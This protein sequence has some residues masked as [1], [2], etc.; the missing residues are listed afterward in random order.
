MNCYVTWIAILYYL[1]R[2]MAYKHNCV[3]TIRVHPSVHCVACVCLSA[4]MNERQ[5]E[6]VLTVSTAQSTNTH[7]D[8]NGG[9]WWWWW[10][11]WEGKGSTEMG[12]VMEM[13]MGMWMCMWMWVWMKTPTAWLSD[14]LLPTGRVAYLKDATDKGDDSDAVH[15]G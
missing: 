3:A 7:A 2:F 14:P 5:I 6:H 4:R 9:R 10:W 1:H 11:W 12:A 8:T 15:S 13:W